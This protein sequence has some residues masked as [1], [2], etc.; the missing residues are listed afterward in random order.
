MK[1]LLFLSFLISNHV[2]SLS[3]RLSGRTANKL[4]FDNGKFKVR[5]NYLPESQ[6]IEFKLRVKTTGYVALGLTRTNSGME[7]LDLFVGGFD[8][9][10]QTAYLEDRHATSLSSPTFDTNQDYTL[11]SASEHKGITKIHCR[12]KLITN[13]DKDFQIKAGEKAYFAWAT[14]PRDYLQYHTKR[15]YSSQMHVLVPLM[16]PTTPPPTPSPTPSSLT[17]KLQFNNGNFNLTWG[18]L[19]ES[20]EIEFKV[21][22]KT[23]GYVAV[24]M[25]KT[26]Y[27]MKDLD[28]FFAGV[29][30]YSRTVYLKDKHVNG[31]KAPRQDAKQDYT[32]I[33][34]SQFGGITTIHCKRKLI[35]NDNKDIQIQAGEKVYFAFATHY[36]NDY[37]SYHTS[38]GY[39]SQMYEI[40][41]AAPPTPP[42]APSIV[43]DKEISFRNGIYRMF[44]KFDST[45]NELFFKLRARA[46][47]WVGLGLSNKNRHMEEMDVVIAGVKD[48][49]GYIG[50]YFSY[51]LAVPVKDQKQDNI[52]LSATES[53]RTT[54]VEFKRK[55]ATGD[56]MDLQIKPGKSY[57]IGWAY[58]SFSDNLV[59]HSLRGYSE[60]KVVLI[61]LN[62]SSVTSTSSS[63]STTTQEI[64]P[65]A[66]TSSSSSTTTTQ[67]IPPYASSST[68]AKAA[69]VKVQATPTSTKLMQATTSSAT[70]TP[71]LQEPTSA[72]GTS[73]TTTVTIT[74][75]VTKTVTTTLIMPTKTTTVTVTVTATPAKIY[76]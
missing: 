23:T 25:T 73:A 27:G 5:W 16:F 7:D 44:W 65:Y 68:T 20:Q 42:I 48:G 62:G 28:L 51:Q 10:L 31:Y 19:S 2:I 29:T 24:G 17:N 32:L 4:Q 15:G 11:I 41:P 53:D 70:P 57:Y 46:N 36:R 30:S 8:G 43:Y 66:P 63:S 3:A 74:K 6:E 52:L 38:R 21:R 71:S 75:T 59:Y 69:S 1:F 34:G 47:G 55:I 40:V 50:D 58:Q 22:A 14:H 39:S 67:E 26:N 37:L 18:Y 64:P 12:R 61:E 54:T 33:S 49:H 45:T 13:D 72:A 35:T 9:Y 76:E 56:Y 60:Q